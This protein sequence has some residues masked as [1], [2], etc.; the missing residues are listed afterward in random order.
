MGMK[1]FDGGH[2]EEH[3]CEL[4]RAE[5]L[6]LNDTKIVFD[7]YRGEPRWRMMI[8]TED[9]SSWSGGCNMADARIRFC[10]FC[11]ANLYVLEAADPVGSAATSV[12]DGGPA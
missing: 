4:L 1:D 3:D 5:G 10:P 9:L 6:A 12:Q 8:F 11:G 2:Q 7:D